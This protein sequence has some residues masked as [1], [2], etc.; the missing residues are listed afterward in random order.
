M[1]KSSSKSQGYILYLALQVFLMH[2]LTDRERRR[3]VHL[4]AFFQ[5]TIN[6]KMDIPLSCLSHCVSDCLC[7]FL[8]SPGSPC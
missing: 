3:T 1:Y 7:A 6:F 4:T 8:L 2:C 5:K